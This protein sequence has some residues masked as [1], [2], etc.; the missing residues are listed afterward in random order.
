ML[1][2][3]PT[4]ADRFA[5]LDEKVPIGDYNYTHFRTEHLLKDGKRTLTNR[6]ILAGELAP[7]FELPRSVGGTLR[8]SELRGQPVIL[9]FG[10]YS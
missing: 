4:A 8:L 3:L 7:D 2:Q 10:S 6:G 9:H 5:A 1:Q